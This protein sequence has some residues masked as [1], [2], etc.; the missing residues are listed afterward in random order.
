MRFNAL[1][2]VSG[3]SAVALVGDP[4]CKSVDSYASE[5]DSFNW[6]ASIT[7]CAGTLRSLVPF[8]ASTLRD[9]IDE[10]QSDTIL[11]AY[12]DS[13]FREA[14]FACASCALNMANDLVALFESNYVRE[15][16][17]DE[18]SEGHV[19][20]WGHGSNFISNTCQIYLRVVVEAFNAC[21]SNGLTVD[22]DVYTLAAPTRCTVLGFRDLQMNFNVYES[23]ALAAFDTGYDSPYAEV[24]EAAGMTDLYE[25]WSEDCQ[26]A[27]N[28]FIGDLTGITP[29][30]EPEC[31]DDEDNPDPFGAGCVDYL[32]E[33][34]ES[35]SGF[36]ANSDRGGPAGYD[37]SQVP[38]LHCTDTS[39]ISLI[40]DFI[41]PY[42]ALV[43]CAIS[44]SAG[45][46]LE[47]ETCVNELNGFFESVDS[48][49]NCFDCFVQYLTNVRLD[50]ATSATCSA[51]PLAPECVLVQ[52]LMNGPLYKFAMCAGFE[53][54][55]TDT[56]CV[57]TSAGAPF[58]TYTHFA[59]CGLMDSV[60][61]R[62]ACVANVHPIDAVL[63]GEEI[64]ACSSCYSRLMQDFYVLNVEN[65]QIGVVCQNPYTSDCEE[66]LAP[67]LDRF[68]ECSGIVLTADSGLVCSDAQ[69]ETIEDI[70]FEAVIQFA[71]QADS[72]TEAFYNFDE[73]VAA[74]MTQKDLTWDDIPCIS[75]FYG[76][77]EAGYNLSVADKEVCY[78]SGITSGSCAL[79]FG[80]PLNTFYQ[81]SGQR[82]R[83]I[84]VVQDPP[85][86][87]TTTTTTTVAATTTTVSTTS[88]H[89]AI[90]ATII[91]VALVALAL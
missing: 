4:V 79:V 59:T 33:D 73:Y 23:L 78:T 32:E 74:E 88:K 29:E 48:T 26:L 71:F 91:V 83:F 47:Y 85:P 39:Q 45:T 12:L 62:D 67:A 81:C 53:L 66:A 9:C 55:T 84:E 3:V 8:T 37:L 89:S 36:N 41:R 75:C 90:S 72:I 21:A 80:V 69:F 87:I 18:V 16:C 22:V 31:F 77:M 52:N 10:L 38:S 15:I 61:A 35:F 70:P 86:P 6:F 82:A 46:F 19:Y 57:D 14:E 1:V 5:A 27:F 68:T 20:D 43:H 60:H 28:T 44:V 42:K 76:L 7:Q 30:D 49:F 50:D 25:S 11:S 34:P 63:T 51:D 54:D 2:L 65:P 40:N 13:T 17:F 64:G 56:S 24:Y 58:E